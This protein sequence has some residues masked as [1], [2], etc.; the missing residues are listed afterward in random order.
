MQEFIGQSPFHAGEI[1]AQ[2]RAGVQLRGA[3]IR[4]FMPDQ[5]RAFFAMLP[6]VVIA[7][8]DAAGWPVASTLAGPQGFI[9]SPDPQHLVIDA[10]PDAIDPIAPLLVPHAPFAL[11]GIDLAT[12]RRNR[13]NGRVVARDEQGLQLEVLQ[14]FGNCPQY[15][16]G[17]QAYYVPPA[18]TSALERLPQLDEE[19][20]AQIRNA[21]TFFVATS[22]ATRSGPAFG[23]DIS[24]RGGR[25]GFVRIDDGN[26]LTIPDFRGNRYF[27]T[28]GNLLL[29]PR[30]GLL[31]I[32]FDRGDLLH[33]QGTTEILWDGPELDRIEGAERVWR[34][35]V[36]RV[37][38]RR[39]AVP[40]RWVFREFSP[41]TLATGEWLPS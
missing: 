10:G 20:L 37:W 19:A 16:Q 6:F 35:R 31:F 13:A 3:P 39:D 8:N 11:L 33:V 38:R 25:P 28:L 29:E 14:S 21:D 9:A 41:V 23:A 40:L 4:D 34:V 32:D 30:A 12:R 22:T 15:I 27:N 18:E 17:R 36:E 7:T 5:H 24:H 26:L 2:L 1:E